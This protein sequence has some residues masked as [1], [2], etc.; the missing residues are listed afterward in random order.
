MNFQSIEKRIKS[1]DGLLSLHSIQ[2]EGPFCDTDYIFNR[3]DTG[4]Q[5]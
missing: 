1:A 3:F 2:G 5:A 4:S